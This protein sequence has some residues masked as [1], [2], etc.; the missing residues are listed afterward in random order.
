MPFC[1]PEHQFPPRARDTVRKLEESRIRAVA[2]AALD[3]PGVLPFWFGE[4]DQ[5]TPEFI[6]RA[7]VRSLEAGR[8]FY[9][10]N[11]GQAA[12]RDT[13]SGYLERQHG[14][15]FGRGRIAVTNAGVSALMV[16]MQAIVDPGD[17]V[18]VVTPVWPNLVEIPRIL[19]ADVQPLPLEVREGRWTLDVE[20]LIGA[21]TPDTRLV[22][23]NSPNNP[24]GWTIS[25]EDQRA[26]FEHC[27]RHGI[28]LMGDDVYERLS[29]GNALGAPS[30]LTLGEPEDRIIS[31]NSFSKAWCMTGWRLGWIVAPERLVDEI[32]KLL[33]YNTSCAPEF[34]QQAAEVA[35]SEGEAFIAAQRAGLRSKRDRL[36]SALRD[37][38]G[39]HAP[40]PQGGMY[41]FF[42][43]EGAEGSVR[44][45]EDMI[46]Q[47][48]LGLAPGRAFGPEAEGWLRWCF[49]AEDAKLDE[50]IARVRR[51]FLAGSG[52][53]RRA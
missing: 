1:D 10:H 27:R 51:Y 15:V 16:A 40:E 28:W 25:A 11:L 45:A 38:H 21:L 7:A 50:G 41:A 39:V 13:I 8:T 5:P 14:R 47:V 2:N 22:L 52:A 32:G 44:L 26:L 19:N 37:L 17:K 49:A 48:G 42:R 9:T 24:T 30:V 35:L 20:K 43:V 46:A 36:I 33:E 12:L 4:S 23:V 29:F 53:S 31:T 6:R 34:V 3:R 18:V